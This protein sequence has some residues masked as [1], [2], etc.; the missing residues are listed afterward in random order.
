MDSNAK[1][2][3]ALVKYNYS[4]ISNQQLAE[5]LDFT[6]DD[7]R[8][9]NMFWEPCFN[10]SW[11]YLSDE[12]ILGELTNEKGP[13]ALKHF[14]TRVLITED[15]TIDIDYKK[16]D[17]NDELVKKYEEVYCPKKDIRKTSNRKLYYAVTGETY[18]DLLQKSANKKGK[19]TRQYYRKVEQLAIF[20]K[21]Y[22][23]ALHTN[24]MKKQLEEKDAALNRMHECHIELI[25]YKKLT[26]K[27]ESIYIAATHTYATQGIFKIGRT[28]CIKSRNSSHNTT[29]V[30]GDNVK[31]LKEF[32]VNDSVS[33]ENYI[34]KKLRGLLVNNEKE[35]F[36][37]PY[38]LLEDI[39]DEI[40]NNDEEHS[41]HINSIID[42][43]YQ[44]KSANYSS[45]K[46]MEGIDPGIFKNESQLISINATSG[47]DITS[48]TIEQKKE[49]V[50][51]CLD[52]YKTTIE[53]PN[54][55][56]W[57]VFQNFLIEAFKQL[58]IPKYKYKAL[59]WKP[60]FNELNA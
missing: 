9:L 43:V 6:E 18:K 44:L 15:Y 58:K 31:V 37:C 20:M 34:H 45:N 10:N 3:D 32:K 36:K 40:I 12:I 60:L 41:K 14:Y 51:K 4:E 39:L 5:Y 57:K 46:W 42:L 23:V 56:V 30:D 22:I 49:F 8:R 27:N 7:L 28:K 11:I 48:A 54:A 2:Q 21:D 17:K 24:A 53:M 52:A 38:N 19:A 47:A 29:H 59:E 25:T 50:S 55:I 13:H 35:F 33:M 1:I 26:E 16:I